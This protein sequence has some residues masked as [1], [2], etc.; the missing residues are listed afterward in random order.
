MAIQLTATDVHLT[1]A[2][3][4]FPNTTSAITF[5]TWLN[6]G[7][8]S[9]GTTASM[10]GVYLPGTTAIQIGTRTINNIDIW[11]WGGTLLV[12][13]NGLYTPPNNTW[14]HVC[15]TY[16]GTTSKVYANGS[17]INSST[18]TQIAGVLTTMY[19]NGY[20]TGAT[21]ETCTVGVDD[22]ILFDRVLTA[23]EIQTIYTSA[24]TTDGVNYGVKARYRYDEQPVGSVVTSIIDYSGNNNQLTPAGTGTI[25]YIT[26]YISN[27]E[28]PV[29]G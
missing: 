13:T 28:R 24:G 14:M 16:D 5:M 15:Y 22:T 20:P 26:T 18:T 2:S 6:Y 3:S 10:V 12:S 19:I 27:D 9:A 17:L 8:W 11:T 7:S 23:D 29:L 25:T 21:N 4:N 1:S